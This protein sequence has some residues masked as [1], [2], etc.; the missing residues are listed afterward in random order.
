MDGHIRRAWF[1]TATWEDKTQDRLPCAHKYWCEGNWPHYSDAWFGTTDAA[2][3]GKVAPWIAAA[4]A[5]PRVILTEDAVNKDAISGDGF[6]TRTG[7]VGV[8]DIADLIID[9]DGLRFKFTK[10]YSKK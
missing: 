2:H 8:F 9:R 4:K 10:R 7:Y 1:A 6:F 3:H 5:D